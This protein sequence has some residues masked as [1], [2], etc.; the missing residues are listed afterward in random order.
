MPISLVNFKPTFLNYFP[1]NLPWTSYWN[2]FFS[3]F[4]SVVILPGS[5][6]ILQWQVLFKGNIPICFAC[7]Y[8]NIWTVFKLSA[9]AHF[10]INLTWSSFQNLPFSWLLIVII[11]P[12]VTINLKRCTQ[13]KGESS[14]FSTCFSHNVHTPLKTE[15]LNCFH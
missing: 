9:L 8:C 10:T 6:G 3:C 4:L 7:F 12:V 13:F 14:V 2:F 11:V 5:T 1:L 15:S